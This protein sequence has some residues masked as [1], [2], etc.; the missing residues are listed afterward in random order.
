L[1]AHCDFL[2]D[3]A[4]RNCDIL[5]YF[6]FKQIYYNLTYISCLKTW[7]VVGIFRFHKWFDVDVLGFQVELCCGYFGLSS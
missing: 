5:G 6:L 3:V 4:Q 2:K 7:F 1:E